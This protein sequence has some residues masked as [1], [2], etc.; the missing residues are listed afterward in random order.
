MPIE[1]YVPPQ[2]VTRDFISSAPLNRMDIDISQDADWTDGFIVLEM[3]NRPVN[4]SAWQLDLYIRT[5]FGTPKLL[6]RMTTADGTIVIEDGP[7]G[8]A[9]FKLDRALVLADLPVG[10]HRQFLVMSSGG[11]NIEIWRGI[12]RVHGG[13]LT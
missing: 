12:M 5:D 2:F 4:I 10:E 6:K 1:P 8:L 13:L 11:V 3:D 9:A 7:A